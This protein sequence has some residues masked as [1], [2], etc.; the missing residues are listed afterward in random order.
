MPVEGG[1]SRE[2]FRGNS[3]EW[4]GGIAW[5]PDSRHVIFS[6]GSFSGKL[7]LWRVPLSGGAAEPMGVEMNWL[8]NS[9]ISVHPDGR[10]IAFHATDGPDRYSNELW[11][12]ENFL[13]ETAVE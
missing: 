11:V 3:G 2:L 7:K 8:A 1:E 4:V 5:T 12:M 13:P 9:G 6:A 10:R